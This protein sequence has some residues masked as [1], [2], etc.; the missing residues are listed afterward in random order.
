MFNAF[1]IICKGFLVFFNV[2]CYNNKEI[3]HKSKVELI[4]LV[5]VN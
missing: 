4:H 5:S 3:D 2:F 1:L